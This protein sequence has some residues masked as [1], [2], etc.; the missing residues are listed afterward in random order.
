[1]LKE[2]IILGG[3]VGSRLQPA[4]NDRPKPL[5]EV[6]GRPFITIMMDQLLAAGVK[7]FIISTGHMAE[8][9]H[10]ILGYMYGEASIIYSH[11][12]EPLGTGGAFN[13]AQ[14]LVKSKA[15]FAMNGDDFVD[16]DFKEWALWFTNRPNFSG[17]ILV[18]PVRDCSAYGTVKFGEKNKKITSF[19]EKG[20][21]SGEGYIST[22][23]YILQKDLFEQTP[24]T[25]K[26]SIE[27]DCFPK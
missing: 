1:M 26:F 13:K 18:T 7:R 6:A 8:K 4:V 15:F 27:Y 9:Y 25:E 17:S 19:R 11:E 21:G 24:E 12:A 22:G 20:K 5:A 14:R 16:F 2:A 10:Q 3:G 23:V